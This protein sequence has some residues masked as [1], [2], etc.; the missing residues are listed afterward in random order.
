MRGNARRT[1]RFAAYAA[2]AGLA[3]S[4]TILAVTPVE[5]A[6]PDPWPASQAAAWLGGQLEDG[7]MHNPN[8]GGFDD[9][10]LSID[11]AFALAVAGG[12]ASRVQSISDAIEA[13]IGSYIGTG[14]ELY[15][16]SA[17]K[18]AVLA[19]VAAEDPTDFGGVD[20]I[21]KVESTVSSTSPIEGR[22]EDQSAFGDFANTLGQSLAARALS[23]AG[24][25]QAAAVTEYL[26]DQQCT[27]G[28]FRLNFSA[29]SAS[30]QSCAE[31]TDA[32]DTDATAYAVLQLAS[33]GSDPDVA[34]AIAQAKTW[35]AAQQRTDGSWGGG[36]STEGSN[37]NST[38]LAAWALGDTG[39]S[40]QA[41][42][43]LRAHQ[44][45]DYDVCDKLANQRGAIAY[46]DAGLAAG[47]SNGITPATQDQ[48][49]R[50][51]AQALPALAY[52]PQDTTPAAPVLTGPAGY[53]KTG[54]RPVLTTSGVG[55]GDQLCLTGVGAAVQGTASGSTWRSAVTLP[56]GTRTRVYTV[57]D[58]FGHTDTLAVKVLGR[59]TLSVTKSKSRV[60]RSR[61]VTATVRYLAPGEWARVFYKGS[62]VR[63]GKATSAGTFSARFRVGRALGKKKIV[64]Y[65]H[66]TDIR[67]G[68]TVIKVVR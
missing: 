37:A 21:Q 28:Y 30:D 62:L 16:G 60:K 68:A 12:N 55:T 32:P 44:A 34:A 15:S 51:S 26:L 8:F 64:G 46:D 38:G 56:A 65:G 17:A 45:T 29:K 53:L 10:G 48:W 52:V 6:T 20:L 13:N 1:S 19:Q 5:A 59:A 2:S 66:F 67:R 49:R 50:A 63:S 23:T 40:E 22:L 54:T 18:S 41:A 39:D 57:R 35:L 58:A 3:I 9:Y 36:T 27:S 42:Q 47:R 4:G 33:Q 61:Y 24:S 43:W 11:A 31:G 25:G 14:S 7:L